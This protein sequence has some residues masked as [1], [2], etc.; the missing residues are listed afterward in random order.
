MGF[1]PKRVAAKA[2]G[3]LG[4]FTGNPVGLLAN[5]GAANPNS[6]IGRA[7]SMGSDI[8]GAVALGNAA[9]GGVR[10]AQGQANLGVNTDLGYAQAP[11]FELPEL[12]SGLKNISAP[13]LG[14]YGFDAMKRRMG[15]F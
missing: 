14:K 2:G 1:D 6:P 7:Y 13:S 5:A 11:K 12:G 10:G 4:L 9:V 8:A 15:G 3:L